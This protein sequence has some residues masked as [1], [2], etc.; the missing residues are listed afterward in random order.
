MEKVPLDIFGVS[1]KIS[2]MV[3]LIFEEL[4]L[5]LAGIDCG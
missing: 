2:S 1:T 3:Y 5:Q 4:Y